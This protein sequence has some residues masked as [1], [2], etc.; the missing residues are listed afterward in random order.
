MG[1][2]CFAAQRCPD[3]RLDYRVAEIKSVLLGVNAHNRA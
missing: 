2:R 1:P 3:C